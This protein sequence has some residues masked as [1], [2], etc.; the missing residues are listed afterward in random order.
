MLN[1]KS[2]KMCPHCGGSHPAGQCPLF[3]TPPMTSSMMPPM[4]SPM[5]PPMTSP[6]MPPMMPP[7]TSPMMPPMGG[8]VGGVMGGCPGGGDM[9]PGMAGMAGMAEMMEHHTQLLEH[10]ACRVDEIYNIV[11][12]MHM[13]GAKG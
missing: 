11:A 5:M 8:L 1:K 10:I 3:M 9:M 12:S 13:G 7:M 2:R 4:T 6:M